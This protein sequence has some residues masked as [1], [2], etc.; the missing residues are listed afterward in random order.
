MLPIVACMVAVVFAFANSAFNVDESKQTTYY[1]YRLNAAGQIPAG[2]V[3]FGGVKQT[4][5]HADA[6]DGCDGTSAL[7]CLRGF[8]APITTFPSTATGEARTKKTN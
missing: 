1:W 5:T 8:S 4:T 7:D 2:S 6:N 3:Q